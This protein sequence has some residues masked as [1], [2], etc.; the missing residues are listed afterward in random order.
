MVEAILELG[1]RSEMA[2]MDIKQAYRMVPV[3]PGDR[4]LLGMN[5]QGTTFL[6][7]V[8]PFGLRS[9][10]KVFNALAN[11][12]QWVALGRG[13]SCLFHYLDDYITLGALG[14]GK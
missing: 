5:W 6:D 9:A 1:R 8:L 12:L 11:A 13:V 4:P 3:S 7:T 14:T 2:K 10:P